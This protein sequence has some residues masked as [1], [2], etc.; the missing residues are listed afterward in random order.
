[1][2]N[3]GDYALSLIHNCKNIAIYVN[4]LGELIEQEKLQKNKR[5]IEL[6]KTSQ[7]IIAFRF[8]ITEWM[9]AM[10]LII[11]LTFWM[12]WLLYIWPR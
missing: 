1:M 7:N 10:F 2:R 3:N 12:N 11:S 4:N 6:H 5:F 8:H 9:M